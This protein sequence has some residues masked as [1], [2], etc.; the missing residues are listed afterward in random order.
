MDIIEDACDLSESLDENAECKD[1]SLKVVLDGRWR[2]IVYFLEKYKD[3][4]TL[5]QFRAHEVDLID[6]LE[7]KL[8]VIEGP[9]KNEFGEALY[10]AYR[11][12]DII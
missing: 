8:L 7:L 9:I 1:V 5:R 2:G 4:H 12:Y 10:N 3:I 11:K 6:E